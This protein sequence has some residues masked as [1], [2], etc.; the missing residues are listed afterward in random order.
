[1]ETVI[2][3]GISILSSLIIGCIMAFVV[4]RQAK[5]QESRDQERTEMIVS[6]LE[7]TNAS[8]SL[9]TTMATELRDLGKCNGKTEAA[10]EYASAAKHK[11]EDRLR[12]NAAANF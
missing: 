7:T 11:Q 9:S 12:H 6:I 1:M 3:A 8:L 2:S 10:L 4:N 5:R